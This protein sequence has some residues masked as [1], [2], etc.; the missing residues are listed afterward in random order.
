MIISSLE[1]IIVKDRIPSKDYTQF[2]RYWLQV[3]HGEWFGLM[4]PWYK[5]KTLEFIFQ[6]RK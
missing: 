6:D 4:V 3:G 5:K 1:S 2:Q